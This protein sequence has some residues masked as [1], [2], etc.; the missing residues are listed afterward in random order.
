MAEY[1]QPFTAPPSSVL[2]APVSVDTEHVPYVVVTFTLV[3][4]LPVVVL[5][6]LHVLPE[7]YHPVGHVVT[8]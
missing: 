8:L 6:L 2:H 1:P 7:T 5:D 3:V 4:P